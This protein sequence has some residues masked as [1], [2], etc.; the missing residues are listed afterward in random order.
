M[1]NSRLTALLAG[2]GRLRSG[3]LRGGL[4]R[5]DDG[6]HD[7][8]RWRRKRSRSAPTSPIRRSRHSAR[9]DRIQGLRRRPDGRDRR[10]D[11]PRRRNSSTPRSTRSS[12]TCAQGKFDMVASATTITD[13][14]EESVD[15]S[16][17]YYLPSAQSIVVKTGHHRHQDRQRPRPGKSSASSRAPPVRNTSKKKSTPRNFAPTRRART[18]SRA[19]KAGTIDAVVIDRPVAERAIE[20]DPDTRN[21]RR[22]RNGR[23]VWI[24][25]PAGRR[26]T[27]GRTERGPGGSPRRRDLQTIYKKWFGK[28]PPPEVFRRRTKRPD[29]R[30]LG[31]ARARQTERGA[32]TG[33]PFM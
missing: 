14:R 30:R 28:P 10:E 3:G 21:R 19:L 32:G 24:R 7:R 11:R 18:R 16:N 26:R 2:A 12:A 31:R 15:F 33:A 4:R 22:D 13:E 17:P 23:R 8:R 6:E 1:S 9:A 20:E 25:G 5:S 27:A 29:D